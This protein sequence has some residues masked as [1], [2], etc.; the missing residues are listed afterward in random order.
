MGMDRRSLGSRDLSVIHA[1]PGAD[2][3]I[4]SE[5]S[6]LR[7]QP[8]PQ[9][10]QGQLHPRLDQQPGRLK[11]QNNTHDGGPQTELTSASLR[12]RPESQMSEA[13]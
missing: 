10:R 8:G 5:P 7:N 9:H 13:T 3:P 6:S 4:S 12:A 11:F 1:F 2:A